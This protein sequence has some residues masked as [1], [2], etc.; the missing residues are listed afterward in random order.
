MF[1]QVIPLKGMRQD[2]PHPNMV[3]V[4]K[5]ELKDKDT[6]KSKIKISWKEDI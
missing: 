4:D 6:R 3:I 1:A 2:F 5:E